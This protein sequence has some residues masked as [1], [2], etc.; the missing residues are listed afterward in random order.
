MTM[1]DHLDR[2]T[3]IKGPDPNLHSPRP[4]TPRK[5]S[6]VVKSLPLLSLLLYTLLIFISFSFSSKSHYEY[7]WS[8]DFVFTANVVFE[9]SIGFYNLEFIIL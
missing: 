2:E 6:L 9:Q 7:E 5:V 1:V 8:F 4:P 3:A